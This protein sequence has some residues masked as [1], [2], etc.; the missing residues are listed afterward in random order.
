MADTHLL[1]DES[2]L[3]ELGQ[4][5]T[6]RRLDQGLTQAQL[7]NQAG[8]SKRTVERLEAGA[9]TQLS[10]LVRILRVL[11]LQE[12]LLRLVPETGPSPMALLKLKGK[13]RKRASTRRKQSGS[14]WGWGDEP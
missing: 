4:R 1:S 9:S 3:E 8:V 10:N 2:V 11:G 12:D 13:Q 6:R 14:G 7:A 5:L